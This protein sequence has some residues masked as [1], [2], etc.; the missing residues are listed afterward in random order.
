MS[1]AFADISFTPSVKAAQSLY[2]SR[3]ANRGFEL[4]KEKRDSLLPQDMEFIAARD[5]FYQAT[6]SEN[7]WPYVQHRGGPAGFLKILDDK[8]IAYADFSGNAQYLSVGNLFASDRISLILM[9][10]ANRRRMKIWGHAKI[11]HEEDD[12]R[13]IARLEMP[14]YR[15]RVERAVV[16][17]VEAIEWNCPQH[18]TPR[19]TE[20]EV[21][22]MLARLLAENSQL[23]Q[24]LKQKAALVKP[25]RLGN[26]P[27]EL[28]ITAMR[29]LSPRIRAYELRDPAGKDLP[30]VGAGA[31]LRVPVLLAGG[32]AATRHYS[33]S[34]AAG[35]TDS[36]EIAV[37]AEPKGRGGSKAVHDLYTL[38]MHLHCDLPRNDFALHA[39]A[40]PAILITGGIGITAIKPMAEQLATQG[41]PY[42]LHYAG[43]EFSA[44][45]YCAEL[46]IQLGASLHL[47]AADQQQRLDMHKIM[48]EASKDS[49]FYICGPASMIAAALSTAAALGIDQQRVRY[50][51]FAVQKSTQD[52]EIRVELARSKKVIHVRA[53]QTILQAVRAHGV[54]AQAEC[55]TGNCGTCAVKLLG[56]QAQHRDAV[57]TEAEQKDRICICVSRA[58]AGEL[59]LDL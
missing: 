15:A 26:G 9:D 28:V 6:I 53:D 23:E 56:G 58:Q 40:A 45:A 33:I 44:M 52:E 29:Q 21:Q 8:T 32:Q 14:D 42:T 34:S 55:E 39:H 13:L 47:Y 11:I 48:E 7:G 24:Q 17:T 19:F 31:H 25:D 18:I 36:Y 46:Q 49:L 54:A 57:L 4:V 2:G 16:I 37:L 22:G 1:R 27:L 12:V 3:E 51:R 30:A 43:R 20:K 35:Q 59:V 41:R 5:S 50:E 10:Y 38:G